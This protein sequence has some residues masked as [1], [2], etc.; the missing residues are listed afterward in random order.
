M[1]L[2]GIPGVPDGTAVTASRHT[3]EVGVPAPRLQRVIERG[4]S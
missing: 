2:A 3:L 4:R 1:L